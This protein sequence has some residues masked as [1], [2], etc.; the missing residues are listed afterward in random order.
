VWIFGA[1][2]AAVKTDRMTAWKIVLD[3]RFF[4]EDLAAT[5]FKD[6]TTVQCF[7]QFML[8]PTWFLSFFSGH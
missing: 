8:Q 1:S 5:M 3:L 4:F 7:D 2:A 6:H